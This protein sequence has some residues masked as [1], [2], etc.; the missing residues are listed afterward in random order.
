VTSVA[1]KKS[2]KCS[3]TI[4]PIFY[5]RGQ[6]KKNILKAVASV[7]VKDEE[8]KKVVGENLDFDG[9]IWIMLEWWEGYKKKVMSNE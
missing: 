6:T 3:L 2:C 9:N 4:F 5:I 8:G 7:A 1:N